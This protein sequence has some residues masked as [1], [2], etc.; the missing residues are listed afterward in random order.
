MATTTFDHWRRDDR[1][2][3]QAIILFNV[4]FAIQLLAAVIYGV[5]FQIPPLT[6]HIFLLPFVWIT[7]SVLAVWYTTPSEAEPRRKLFAGTISGGFLL[8]FL[9]L[10]GTVGT[11]TEVFEQVTGPSAITVTADRSLGWSPILF[12]SGEWFALRVIPYQLIG[13]VALS[14]LIYAAIL[15]IT[16]SAKAGLLGLALCPGC[17]AALLAPVLASVAGIS[18]AFALFVRYTYEISTVLFVFAVAF[19]YWEPSLAKLRSTVTENIPALTAALAVVV[20]W[21]HLFHPQ[22]GVFRLIEHAQAGVLVDPRPLAFTLAGL[23]IFAGVFLAY[24]GVVAKKPLYLLGMALMIT[25]MIGYASWHT[26]LDHGG[27]W[28]HI[29]AHGH[30]D[31]HVVETIVV[32]LL[33]DTTALL[34]KLAELAV[35][36]LLIV[37]YRRE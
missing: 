9:Y 16:R 1:I 23:A 22:H 31:Q 24:A 29:E 10:S 36:V 3:L 12:Y 37:L 15:D 13:Y 35:L 21:L 8:V 20:A 30:H 6:L 5:V 28:P 19:I 32:H 25:F 14:Y 27:F 17:S 2:P 33:A 18:S 4:L 7:V 11:S 26:V 34:S